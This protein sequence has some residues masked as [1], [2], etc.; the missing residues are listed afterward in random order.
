MAIENNKYLN[1]PE[2][3]IMKEDNALDDVLGDDALVTEFDDGSVE[4]D[5]DKE[6]INDIIQEGVVDLNDEH[7][8]NLAEDLDESLLNDIGADVLDRFENDQNSRAEW[9]ETINKGLTLLGINSDSSEEIFPGSCTATH[10]MILEAAVKF[11][12]KASNELFN[13]KGPVKTLVI[14]TP[15]KEKSDQAKRI[16]KHMNYQVMEQMEEF[17]DETERMLLFLPIVGSGFKKTYYDASL[18]RPVSEF[19]M[20]DDFVVNYHTTDLKTAP[21]FTHVITRTA[22]DLLKD[23]VS[24]LYR[25]TDI[26]LPAQGGKKGDTEVVIN[27][28]MGTQPGYDDD[29]YEILEQYCELDLEG[30]E[31]RDS[32][33]IALPY[34][35][36]V[37]ATTGTV[38]AIRRNWR[39]L[40]PNR[41]LICPFTHYKF[42]PG[43]G[44]YGL[45][46]IHLLGNLQKTLTA[47][48]RSLI[49][50]GTFAN[51]QGGFVDKSVK[52]RGDDGPIAPGQFKEVE[53]MGGN[54]RDKIMA[55]PFKEPSQTLFMMFQHVEARGQ[56]FADS[57]EQVVADSTN[58]GPVGTTM[59]LL[60]ASTKFFSGVHK[61]LHKAQKHEFRLLASLNYE[62]L[63]ESE[64]FDVVGNTFMISKDDY[65]GRIDVLPVSDPNIG[66]QSQKMALAQGVY[67]SAMQVP[68]IHDMKNVSRFYYSAMG[69]DEDVVDGFI[70]P[71]DEAQEADPLTDIK[72]VQQGKPI[73][74]FQGQDHDSHIA[75][76][77][78]FLQDPSSGANPM[79]GNIAPLIQANI[80]EH[81]VLKF[82]AQ[83][84]G[85]VSGMQEQQGAPPEMVV[86]QAAQKI[87]QNNA[88][89]Q[90]LE[91]K[92]VDSA[93]NKLADAEL[94][95][96]VND[97]TRI[98]V[99][100]QDKVYNRTYDAVKLDLEKYKT[101]LK[102]ITDQMK[103][104]AAAQQ[105]QFK[106]MSAIMKESLKMKAQ[107]EAQHN[108]DDK[109]V[110]IITEE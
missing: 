7:Y 84:S 10:P 23:Q 18:D 3:L 61:R 57:T 2:E 73:K 31:S 60:E 93:R 79:M 89:L 88:R 81:F 59:A 85:E 106:E 54:I 83:V 15:D 17:F 9:L 14:G 77:T 30:D 1:N 64:T 65:D 97:S 109:G 45:G 86:A 91:E 76:K 52:M 26:S 107:I 105:T 78:A 101:E 92:G 25:D 38:L 46:F 42:V 39:E 75:V 35:V 50:S 6:R 8:A 19:I 110:D 13:P 99:D 90:E 82:I 27:D 43:F 62:Y 53:T 48:L 87:A 68:G 104:Q 44:F 69:I 108:I 41:R 24:G 66:S 40:D 32:D 11:Q 28:M 5:F 80:Q 103:A 21:C 74:A 63:G 47:T 95:R 4:F 70:K 58:Y 94:Q 29:V 22:N 12:A 100:T 56:R 36:S 96:A 34:V 71:E 67:S 51:L 102:F 33:G 49:D 16:G 20:I 98:E 55:L 37:E 72:N